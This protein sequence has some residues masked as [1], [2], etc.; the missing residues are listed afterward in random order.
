MRAEPEFALSRGTGPAGKTRGSAGSRSAWVLIA[1]MMLAVGLGAGLM[2]SAA[3]TPDG[4]VQPVGPS[5]FPVEVSDFYDAQPVELRL[6]QQPASELFAPR[7]GVVTRSV[8][9]DASD[10]VSG[11]SPWSID[12]KPVLAMATKTPLYRDI[13]MGDTGPDVAALRDELLRLGYE[14]EPSNRV[15]NATIAAWKEAQKEIGLAQSDVFAI[16]D[17]MWLPQTGTA[18]EICTALLGNRVEEGSSMASTFPAVVALELDTVPAVGVAGK[19]QLVVGEEDLEVGENGRVTDAKII[20][21]LLETPS[22]VAAIAT[23]DSEMQVTLPGDYALATPVS[24][25]TI[26]A[27]AVVGRSSS[28]VVDSTGVSLT[29]EIVGSSLARSIVSFADGS[30]PAKVQVSPPEGTTCN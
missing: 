15:D 25:A 5:T 18:I 10:L 8:C 11:E 16:A 29:V 4:L 19:R 6:V 22:G 30:P 2:I 14:V 1:V 20:Q 17:T 28:C 7:G 27:S 13:G 24:A 12:G 21:R 26:P 23:S 9:P 3:R